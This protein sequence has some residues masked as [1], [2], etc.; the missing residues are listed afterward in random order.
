M[1]N[2]QG[3]ANPVTWIG[4]DKLVVDTVV[5]TRPLR[6]GRVA[7]LAED[8]DPDLVGVIHVSPRD[9][10]MYAIIDGQHRVE[11]VRR[12]LG[13]DQN[14][15][16][17]V[18]RRIHTAKQASLFVGLNN[19]AKVPVLYE[20]LG[21]V[22]ANQPD[23]VAI[24]NI[25]ESVGLKFSGTQSPGNIRCVGAL[26]SVYA[27]AEDRG[28]GAKALALTLKVVLDA[29]GPTEVAVMGSVIEGIG[30]VILR[31]GDQLD[32]EALIQKL[33]A[34]KGGALALLGQARQV[35]EMRG[36]TVA[37]GFAGQVVTLY[38][39]GRRIAALTDWWTRQ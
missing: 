31:Y 9:R 7:Q 14:V 35:K 13:G 11:A 17:W 16:C 3:P 27:G 28:V 33:A 2:G 36:G 4:V 38:N 20:F 39:K 30:L 19:S 21:R 10:G 29:W 26:Q 24:A 6:E 22:N 32:P 37:R 5:N 15:P 34:S 1:T 25:V 23:A 18:H 8:F 12:A